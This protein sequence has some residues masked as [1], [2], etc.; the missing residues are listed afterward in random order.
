MRCATQAAQRCRAWLGPRRWRRA[1]WMGW[2][3]GAGVWPLG[4]RAGAGSVPQRRHFRECEL[5]LAR[6]LTQ[7]AA[8]YPQILPARTCV[9]EYHAVTTCNV[10]PPTGYVAYE[11]EGACCAP[12]AWLALE[13]VGV[14]WLFPERTWRVVKGW[15][16]GVGWGSVG[17]TSPLLSCFQGS[18]LVPEPTLL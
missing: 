6:K 3:L 16:G 1:A 7:P 10:Q 13:A 15:G 5:Q 9:L 2:G 18:G 17:E 8:S 12:V 14:W 4:W 11:G